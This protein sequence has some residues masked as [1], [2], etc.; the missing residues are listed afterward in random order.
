[1]NFHLNKFTLTLIETLLSLLDIGVFAV[2]FVTFL[3]YK[4]VI[5][6]GELDS[7][8]NKIK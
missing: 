6:L 1:M 7:G 2:V 3:T 5:E 8:E 4:S